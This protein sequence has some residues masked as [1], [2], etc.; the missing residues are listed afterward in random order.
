MNRDLL[1]EIGAEELPASY[2]RPALEQLRALAETFF[3][4]QRLAHGTIRVEGTPRR[5]ALM[6]RG[7]PERQ[8]D[9]HEEV[10]G[11]PA[12]AAFD[13]DGKPTAVA[14]GFAKGKGVEVADLVV[15]GTPKGDYV[16]AQVHQPGRFTV[17]LLEAWLPQI[18]SK[19][20]FPK[21]MRWGDGGPLRFARPISWLCALYGKR[22]LKFELAHLRSGASTRGHRFLGTKPSAPIELKDAADYEPAL[23]KA[24]VLLSFDERRATLLKLL[25]TAAKKY[26]RLVPD[27]DLLDVVAN[28]LEKPF[29][30]AGD[31]DPAYLELPKPVIVT[32]LREH[33]FAFACERPDGS[34]APVFLATTN[35]VEKN[36]AAVRDGNAR[37]VRARLEDAR[38]F[39]GEDRK[40]SL[41]KRRDE[42][43][44]VVWQEKLGTVYE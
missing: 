3:S 14:L 19:L 25:E 9:R 40:V 27:P 30:L 33:Q 32:V 39:F 15:K 31:F 18:P 17:E 2:I 42:L 34:L 11:P 6:V 7:I 5:L 26:G 43:K 44:A 12:K 16:F 10:L 23:A 24:H 20:A 28:L 1:F 4:E 38:F 22:T 21:S 13:A 29:V 35:G 41:E 37:V 36:S 8:E